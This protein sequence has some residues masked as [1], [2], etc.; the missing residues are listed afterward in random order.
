MALEEVWLFVGEVVSAGVG[1]EV[2]K[3]HTRCPPAPASPP[4]QYRKL[5][6]VAPGPA[7]MMVMD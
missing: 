6:A 1:F 4:G 7:G 3:V 5:S 2:S